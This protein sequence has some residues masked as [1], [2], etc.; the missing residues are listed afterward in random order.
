MKSHSPSQIKNSSVESVN[1]GWIIHFVTSFYRLVKTNDSRILRRASVNYLLDNSLLLLQRKSSLFW[2]IYS[3]WR[4]NFSSKLK[5]NEGKRLV[6]TVCSEVPWIIKHWS[7]I[8]FFAPYCTNSSFTG[9]SF[10]FSK[11]VQILIYVA[12][13]TEKTLP[14]GYEVL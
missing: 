6:F 5:A 7:V 8:G 3:W 9:E 14:V 1:V 4:W 2:W 12:T 10:L 13:R 11:D